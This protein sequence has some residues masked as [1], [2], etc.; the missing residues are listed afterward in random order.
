MISKHIPPL[1]LT[2]CLRF[3]NWAFTFWIETFKSV[4]G[5]Y[6][7]SILRLFLF[8]REFIWFIS[9]FG[10]QYS[11]TSGVRNYLF[12][13]LPPPAPHTSISGLFWL[14]K[15]HRTFRTILMILY[16]HLIKQ[17][18]FQLQGFLKGKLAFEEPKKG[19]NCFIWWFL[20]RQT[21]IINQERVWTN[22]AQKSLNNFIYNHFQSLLE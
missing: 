9:E 6:I 15:S 12:L 13:P 8:N 21:Q 11:K 2:E 20:K 17:G 19:F 10:I 22:L 7:L 4:V 14:K 5:N 1:S 3:C 18:D 16:G